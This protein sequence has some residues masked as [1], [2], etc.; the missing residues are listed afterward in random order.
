MPSPCS[1]RTILAA[2]SALLAGCT[3][4]LPQLRSQSASS[5]P[6]RPFLRERTDWSL[7]RYD[8]ANTNRIPAEVAPAQSLSAEWTTE[9][10]H[11][12]YPAE[13]NPPRV[14]SLVS[15]DGLVYI[16]YA[17]GSQ[18]PSVRLRVLNAATGDERWVVTLGKWGEG[19]PISV[20]I[21]GETAFFNANILQPDT[22][23]EW[24]FTAMNAADGAQFWSQ[25]YYPA[26]L[27]GNHIHTLSYEGN[28]N[29]TQLTARDPE[30]GGRCW[31]QRVSSQLFGRPAL[32]DNLVVYTAGRSGESDQ[33]ESN[34]VVSFDPVSG[35]HG[36]STTIE[37]N[38]TN[39][40]LGAFNTEPVAQGGHVIVSTSDGRIAALDATT[41][42][43]TWSNSAA[44]QLTV[45]SEL[46]VDTDDSDVSVNAR[47]TICAATEDVLLT[48]RD[49]HGYLSDSVHALTRSTGKE[50]WQIKSS[51]DEPVS[52]STPIVAGNFVYLTAWRKG[53][54]AGTLRVYDLKSGKEQAKYTLGGRSFN[55]PIVADRRVFVV[56]DMGVQA[57]S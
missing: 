36:W 47:R 28:D 40:R 42:T 55:P 5:C 54:D 37:G 2:S 9:F 51:S 17:D 11:V 4:S 49:T 6:P 3:S 46:T 44:V 48:H 30:T 38:P 8:E 32:L 21:G 14:G 31:T 25:P 16:P 39:E 26:F 7:P 1:R 29:E 10:E 20:A 27:V 50:R 19:L 22:S 57:F 24:Q 53:T 18:D 12:G 23:E 33:I 35:E 41:G 34:T 15:A 52:L 43:V 45:D 13:G 56:T